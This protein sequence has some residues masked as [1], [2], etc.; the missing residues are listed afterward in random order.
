MLAPSTRIFS[1]LLVAE[2]Y[3]GMRLRSLSDR[4]ESIGEIREAHVIYPT[5]PLKEFPLIGNGWIVLKAHGIKPSRLGK[6]A[7]YRTRVSNV[8]I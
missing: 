4:S 1:T 5:P 6:Q 2:L 8:S 3:V 7:N